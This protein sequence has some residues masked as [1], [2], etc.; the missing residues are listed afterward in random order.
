VAKVLTGQLV[1]A[2]CALVAVV[3]LGLFSVLTEQTVAGLLV[4]ILG[5][6]GLGAGHQA[7]G[8]AG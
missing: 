4:G 7:N 1:I 2:V 3:V 5:G 6:F 8:K